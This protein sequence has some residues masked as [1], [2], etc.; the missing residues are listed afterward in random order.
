[1][2]WTLRDNGWAFGLGAAIL[3]LPITLFLLAEGRPLRLDVDGLLPGVCGSFGMLVACRSAYG[4]TRASGRLVER[5]VLLTAMS[6]GVAFA[7]AAVA[8]AITSTTY[9]TI[10]TISRQPSV[11]DI[12]FQIYFA[13]LLIAPVSMLVA[14]K[15][16]LTKLGVSIL[17]LMVVWSWFYLTALGPDLPGNKRQSIFRNNNQDD[18]LG[19]SGIL[20]WC[21][22]G[23]ASVVAIPVA[24]YMGR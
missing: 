5:I 21:L 18:G 9:A 6:F 19:T 20:V 8:F 1:M 10:F 22:L 2:N 4:Y 11:R 23:V 17:G 3:S 15:L 7:L 14:W 12:F 24:T 13:L 16:A